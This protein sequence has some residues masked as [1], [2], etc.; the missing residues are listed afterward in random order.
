[1]L[2]RIFVRL[3]AWVTIRLGTCAGALLLVCWP[4]WA[5]AGL[6][7]WVF[8]P[9]PV[10][11]TAAEVD[12]HLQFAALVQAELSAQGTAIAMISRSGLNL[13][14]IGHRYSHAGF[15]RPWPA[16]ASAG[17]PAAE[18][19]GV[20]GTW[21]VRQ[22][23][24]DCETA[25]PRVFDEGLAGFVRG[26]AADAL[27][28]LSVVWW[29]SQ[30]AFHL[31]RAVGD[32]SLASAML[33]PSYQAQAHAWSTQAQNCNQWLAEMLA[34]A[35]G[36]AGNRTQAQ[37]WLREQGYAGSVVQLPWVGWM[38]AAALLPHMGLQHHPEEDLQALRFEV[39]LPAAIERFAHERWPQARRVE[40]CLK[41]REVVVRRSWEPLDAACTPGEADERRVLD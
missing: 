38:I 37:R 26:V 31:A 16:S 23:Y 30:A 29:P 8:C 32:T 36:E 7:G 22:L 5:Q 12:T 9:T 17:E 1:M 15:V 10:A 33:S 39:S 34:A 3:H 11:S 13:R 41:G 6:P 2:G 21:S 25:Q 19:P 18:A 20:R 40:W 27:P 4:G 35:F 14:A 28:R 24:F